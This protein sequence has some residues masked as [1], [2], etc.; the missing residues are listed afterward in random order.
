MS[1]AQVLA[2]AAGVVRL[3]LPIEGWDFIDRK[4]LTVPAG[5]YNLVGDDETDDK[6]AVLDD[7]KGMLYIVRKA[8]LK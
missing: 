5:S 4:K 8:G 1:R 3:K 7:N 6:K 2:E